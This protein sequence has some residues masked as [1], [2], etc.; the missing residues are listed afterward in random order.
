MVNDPAG[1][2]RCAWEGIPALEERLC[3]GHIFR[4]MVRLPRVVKGECCS[5]HACAH[6]HTCWPGSL[7]PQHVITLSGGTAAHCR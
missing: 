4:L 6:T 2:A 7:L 3:P 1:Q 5:W